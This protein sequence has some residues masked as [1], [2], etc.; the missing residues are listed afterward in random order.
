MAHARASAFMHALGTCGTCLF[1]ACVSKHLQ[2]AAPPII[3]PDM[4]VWTCCTMFIRQRVLA[5]GA[6]I[7]LFFMATS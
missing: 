5:C 4:L 2:S 6:G 3:A 7:T 1:P